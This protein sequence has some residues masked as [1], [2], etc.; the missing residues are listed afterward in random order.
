[1]ANAGRVSPRAA[2]PEPRGRRNSVNN[3]LKGRRERSP[4]APPKIT[5]GDGTELYDKDW[6]PCQAVVS[7]SATPSAAIS[8]RLRAC[9]DP[10]LVESLDFLQA[11]KQ[12]APRSAKRDGT[13]GGSGDDV[14]V[15]RAD[16]ALPF[17]L[18]QLA[19]ARVLPDG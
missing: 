16:E 3:H 19:P 18:E 4:N 17:H 12:R 14:P 9:R 8:R 10:Y 13:A 2:A 11:G 5:N 6:G 7:S 1:M 15:D